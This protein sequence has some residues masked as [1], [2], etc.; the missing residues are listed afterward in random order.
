MSRD[1]RRTSSPPVP[2]RPT[3]TDHEFRAEL[4]RALIIVVRACMKKYGFRPP[5]FE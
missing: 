4:W 2:T 3:M 5:T 1:T